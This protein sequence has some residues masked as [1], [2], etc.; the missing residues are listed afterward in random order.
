[1]AKV[2]IMSALP[3]TRSGAA[4]RWFAGLVGVLLLGS[5]FLANPNQ[6]RAFPSTDAPAAAAIPNTATA[7]PLFAAWYERVL[8][9]RT[10]MIQVATIFMIVG[11]A[12][13]LWG[14]SK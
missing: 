2:R 7:T 5:L 13:L 4:W 10:R 6:A 9:D 11:I 8:G 14:K 1:M 3:Q 12:F